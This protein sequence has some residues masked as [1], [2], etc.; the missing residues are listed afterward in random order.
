MTD[1]P[2]LK[3]K[4]L[5][6]FPATAVG[7]AGIDVEKVNGNFVVDLDYADFAPPVSGI[8]DLTHQNILLWNSLT[9]QYALTPVSLFGAGQPVQARKRLTA[10]MTTWYVSPS[11]DDANDGLSAGNP[12][13]TIQA[14]IDIILQN[15]DCAG[16]HPVIQLADGTYTAGANF[17]CDALNRGPFGIFLIGNS[18]TA[19]NCVISTS[20]ADAVMVQGGAHVSIGGFKVQ[21]T[22]SGDCIAAQLGG[23]IANAFSGTLEF[24]P[25]AGSH[26]SATLDGSILC[27][28]DYV[29]S[30]G[31]NAHWHA[32]AEMASIII[33]NKVT[34]TGTPH[35]TAYF[36]GINKGSVQC[37]GVTFVGTATGT[38]FVC[39][40]NGTLDAAGQ[41][42]AFLPGDAPGVLDTDGVYVGSEGDKYDAES[43][44]KAY[45]PGPLTAGGGAFNSVTA[46]GKYKLDGTICH[47]WAEYT[48][49]DVGTASGAFMSGNVLPIAS[50]NQVAVL[51]LN[52]DTGQMVWGSLLA[53]GG[54]DTILFCAVEPANGHRFF[55]N[56]AYEAPP[57]A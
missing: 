4:A 19:S 37:S 9:D 27:V 40:Y 42:R 1:F 34:L 22:G 55:L 14:A 10:D 38:K 11:G 29:I 28:V 26:W 21:T 18:T 5:V 44:W 39:H 32:G 49:V 17:Y 50:V 7:G 20:N 35:F 30:G 54:I 15:I 31:A 24:G 41:T 43:A 6:N 52:G 13:K 51:G 45:T 36:C 46:V 57:T 8:S 47:Y 53:A 23:Y 33:S 12:L 16:F 56:G 2:N 25:S 48:F 3:I